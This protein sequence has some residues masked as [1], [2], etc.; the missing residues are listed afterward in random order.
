MLRDAFMALAGNCMDQIYFAAGGAGTLSS[1]IFQPHGE[2]CAKRF[3]ERRYIIAGHKVANILAGLDKPLP[4]HPPAPE[5][6]VNL[7]P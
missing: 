2:A 4:P 3:G 6:V 7:K 1:E 5:G